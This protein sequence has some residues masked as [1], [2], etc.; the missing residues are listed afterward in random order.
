MMR[1]EGNYTNNHNHLPSPDV[2]SSG[3]NGGAGVLLTAAPWSTP[4][5]GYDRPVGAQCIANKTTHKIKP[6]NISKLKRADERSKTILPNILLGNCQSLTSK[7]SDELLSIC[8]QKDISV[9][10][11]TETWFKE[12]K[13]IQLPGYKLYSTNRVKRSCGGSAIYVKET[14]PVQQMNKYTFNNDAVSATW[15][16]VTSTTNAPSTIYGCLYHPP[17]ACDETTLDYLSKTLTDILTNYPNHSLVLGGDFNRLDCS[18][19]NDVFELIN[20]VDFPTRASA[21]LDKIFTNPK[22]LIMRAKRA[23]DVTTPMTSSNPTSV[24]TGR[25]RK[26]S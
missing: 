4:H 24:E 23:H 10:L 19:L 3:V 7:K 17:D 21:Y 2:G 18:I 6:N 9:I 12:T 20:I 15:V 1:H 13:S 14:L 26:S 8:H 5:P 16:K 11:A 22:T 25:I